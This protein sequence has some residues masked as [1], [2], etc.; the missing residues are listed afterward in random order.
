MEV[1]RGVVCNRAS[2]GVS[3]DYGVSAVTMVGFGR[4]NYHAGGW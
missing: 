3:L 1:S 4:C 2:G